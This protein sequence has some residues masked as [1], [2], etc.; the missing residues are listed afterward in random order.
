MW[1]CPW[2]K[3]AK[4]SLMSKALYPLKALPPGQ[5]WLHCCEY[6][7]PEHSYIGPAKQ[8]VFCEQNELPL[9]GARV[10][11][12]QRIALSNKQHMDIERT[13]FQI[14]IQSRYKSKQDIKKPKA[15]IT[16]SLKVR[17][18]NER[19]SW[20]ESKT[21]RKPVWANSDKLESHVKLGK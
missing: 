3:H 9:A 17:H 11:R 2:L 12:R 15:T 5:S 8:T 18:W 16:W 6:M 19:K 7:I 21:Q 20:R 10:K 14:Q 4:Y 1:I 13:M